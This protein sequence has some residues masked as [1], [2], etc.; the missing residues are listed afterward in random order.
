MGGNF[1]LVLF[2]SL[3]RQFIRIG[4]SSPNTRY[5]LLRGQS[6]VP[7]EK[8]TLCLARAKVERN[9]RRPKGLRCARRRLGVVCNQKRYNEGCRVP[10]NDSEAHRELPVGNAQA[11]S[12]ADPQPPSIANQKSQILPPMSLIDSGTLVPHP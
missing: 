3:S 11:E 4:V 7:K 10:L 12:L 2:V 5:F 9:R 1:A 6:S 8:A